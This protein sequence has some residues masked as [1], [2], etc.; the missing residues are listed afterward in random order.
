[1]TVELATLRAEFPVTDEW[2]YLNHAAIGPFSRRTQA[3]IA[4]VS[5]AFA[6]PHWG[7]AYEEA[8]ETARANAARLVGG[9]PDGVAFV[10]SLADA[11]SLV[12][13]GV[14]WHP[15]DNVVMPS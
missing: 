8:I 10:G 11:M 15:G 3:A 1:M 12:A 9:T 13:A 7:H 4:A 6:V 5:D 2:A 14:D